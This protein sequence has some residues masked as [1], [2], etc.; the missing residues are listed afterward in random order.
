LEKKS[1]N[2]VGDFGVE[3]TK[4]DSNDKESEDFRKLFSM[5]ETKKPVE[6]APE[7][8]VVEKVEKVSDIPVIGILEA[9]IEIP[10]ES[11]VKSRA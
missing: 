6:V 2:S 8:K 10:I 4:F 5:E 3:T 11:P 9:P 7:Q 1:T